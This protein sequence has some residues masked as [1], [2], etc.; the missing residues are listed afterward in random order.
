MEKSDVMDLEKRLQ[1][2]NRKVHVLV[3]D[4]EE[5]VFRYD[6]S[7]FENYNKGKYDVVFARDGQEAIEKAR[8]QK[9]D[10]VVL[11]LIMPVMSG[12]DVYWN[13]KENDPELA[14]KVLVRSAVLGSDYADFVREEHIPSVRKYAPFHEFDMKIQEVLGNGKH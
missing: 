9:F 7:F 11:D 8:E 6:H 13:L 12:E 3:V 2:R 1:H 10:L 4:D 5:D 14:K